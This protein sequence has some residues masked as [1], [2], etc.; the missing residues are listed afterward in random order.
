MNAR[1]REVAP[2]ARGQ[3]LI[4]AKVSDELLVYDTE[5]HEAHCL[6]EAAAL[7][8]QHCDGRTSVD[9]IAAL[10]QQDLGTPVDTDLVWYALA[11]LDKDHLLEEKATRATERPGMSRRQII[12]KVGLAVAIPAIAS[13]AVPVATASTSGLIPCPGSFPCTPGQP[14]NPCANDSTTGLPCCC[15]APNPQPTRF[16]CHPVAGSHNRTPCSP[17]PGT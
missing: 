3:G 4:L 9:E 7:V 17:P 6:N 14:H 12:A 1:G 15:N 13:V 5:R 2:C 11:Q 10:L 16:T 8:F